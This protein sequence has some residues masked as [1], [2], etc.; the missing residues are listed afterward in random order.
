MARD[1]SHE[2]RIE[3]AR[4]TDH[5]CEY[6][7]IHEDDAGFPHQ[8]DHT[9]GRKHGGLSILNNLAYACILCNRHKESEIA[10]IASRTG[11]IVPLF[12]PRRDRWADHFRLE[13]RAHQFDF[14]N[15]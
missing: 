8:V 4:R 13:G 3:I 15:R 12:H 14:R 2:V 7:W 11:E 6:C 9:V 5:R 10:S 1:I